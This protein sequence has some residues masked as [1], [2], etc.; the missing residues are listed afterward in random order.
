MQVKPIEYAQKIN[1]ILA[2]IPFAS[3][4]ASLKIARI[5]LDYRPTSAYAEEMKVQSRLEDSVV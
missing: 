2:E 4:D 3:A 5:L 1:D